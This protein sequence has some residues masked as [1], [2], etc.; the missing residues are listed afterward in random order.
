MSQ[1]G[2]LILYEHREKENINGLSLRKDQIT[3]CFSDLLDDGFESTNSDCENEIICRY[4]PETIK[5][6]KI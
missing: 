3:E 1:N 2:R 4:F 5:R 6:L